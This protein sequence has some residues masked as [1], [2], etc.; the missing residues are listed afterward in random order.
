MNFLAHLVLSP[1][2]VKQMAGNFFA[3]QAKGN[4]WKMLEKEYANGVLLH[5]KIDSFVDSHQIIINAKSFLSNEYGKFKGVLLDIYWDHFLAKDFSIYYKMPRPEF[6]SFCQK[7][8]KIHA[9]FFHPKAKVL[10]EHMEK[11]NWL[12]E[13]SELEGI[14]K[15]LKQMSRRFKYDNPLSDGVDGLRE[16][17]QA[18][19][20]KFDILW[21]EL[22]SQFGTNSILK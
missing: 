2:G 15:I 4:K 12:N 5:R 17:Y 8:L 3:N 7:K 1:G 21:P 13:Y 11:Q 6:V 16:N 22:K 14:E 20:T 18:L 10:V 9:N 19:Q